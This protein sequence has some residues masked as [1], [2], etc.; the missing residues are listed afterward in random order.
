VRWQKVRYDLEKDEG[1]KRK[2]ICCVCR[3]CRMASAEPV[4][5]GIMHLMQKFSRETYRRSPAEGDGRLCAVVRG[6]SRQL[7]YDGSERLRDR[8]HKSNYEACQEELSG[9]AEPTLQNVTA[10]SSLQA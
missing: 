7:M 3:A 5:F 10:P 4:C 2:K 6:C 8:S 1:E 9:D